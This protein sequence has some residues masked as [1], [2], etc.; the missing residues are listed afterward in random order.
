[1]VESIGKHFQ[2]K[3]LETPELSGSC[4]MSPSAE[5]PSNN[6]AK[7]S[8]FTFVV[9]YFKRNWKAEWMMVRLT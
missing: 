7:T 4:C 6:S 8:L 1:M 9:L 2:V 5:H 3:K